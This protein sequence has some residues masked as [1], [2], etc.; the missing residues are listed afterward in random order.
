MN[1]SRS[2]M[3]SRVGWV[4]VCV[5]LIGALSIAILGLSIGILV[6]LPRQEAA[7]VIPEARGLRLLQEEA[8]ISDAFEQLSLFATDLTAFDAALAKPAHP[9]PLRVARAM[10]IV[11]VAMADAVGAATGSFRPYTD[12]AFVEEPASECAALVAAAHD[13][14]VALY[15]SFKSRIEAETAKQLA[16]VAPGALKERGIVL[17]REAARLILEERADDG[18]AHSEPPAEEFESQE[19]GKWRRDPV[20]QHDVALGGR[21]ADEVRPFAIGSADQFRIEAPPPIDSREFALEFAEAVAIGGDGKSTPTV[22]DDWGTMVGLFWAYD[23]T[24]NVC[25]PPRLYLQLA[26]A[27]AKQNSIGMLA[28]VRMAATLAVAMADAGLA[29]WESKYFYRRGRPVTFVREDADQDDNPATAADP[30]WTPLGAPASNSAKP[31]F[32]PPFPAYPSGHATFGGALAQVLRTFIGRDQFKVEFTS[33]EFDGVTRDNQGNI[34]PRVT[35]TFSSATQIEFENGDS[36]PKLGI[37]WRLD[38]TKG[39][40]QGNAVGKFVAERLFALVK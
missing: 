31:N 33:S 36:R 2:T 9:G 1:S 3:S 29:A 11:N 34:R 35:R 4:P 14:L 38:C 10:A 37:H 21:W 22:R 20:A 32:T 13:T 7:G 8:R 30:Q 5:C 25:A 15:P 27:A 40:E 18:S 6:A 12:L 39:I 19:P 16:L 17:G 23:G 24:G 26:F 28:T